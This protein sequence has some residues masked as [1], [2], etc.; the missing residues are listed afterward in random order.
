MSADLTPEKT[1]QSSA[2]DNCLDSPDLRSQEDSKELISW[3]VTSEERQDWLQALRGVSRQETPF[4]PFPGSAEPGMLATDAPG[5]KGGR[6]DFSPGVSKDEL[7]GLRDALT[8]AGVLDKTAA[9]SDGNSGTDSASDKTNDSPEGKTPAEAS[10]LKI[11]YPGGKKSTTCKL[12]G[13][14]NLVE[15]TSKDQKGEKTFYKDE[16][17]NK[18]TSRDEDGIE[19]EVK[20]EFKLDGKDL[21]Y[22]KPGGYVR[23][24]KADGSVVNERMLDDQSRLA[25]DNSGKYATALVRP[26]GS[27]VEAT[28]ERG[29]ITRVVETSKDGAAVTW[30]RTQD[31]QFRSDGQPP[32]HRKEIKLGVQ[33]R[34]TYEDSKGFTHV[35]TGAGSERI[36]PRIT[37]NEDGTSTVEIQYPGGT[38]F[39]N[40]TMDGKGNLV[41]FSEQDEDGRRHYSKDQSGQWQMKAGIKNVPVP[42]DFQLSKN[43]DFIASDKDMYDVQKPDGTIVHE[44]VNQQNGTRLRLDDN[45]NI[46]RLTR[47]DGSSVDVTWKDGEKSKLVETDKGGKE[48]TWTKKGDGTWESDGKPPE[49]RKKFD[50][51][52]EGLVIGEDVHGRRHVTLGDGTK[53]TEGAGGSRF[54]FD[55]DGKITSITYP[56]GSEWSRAELKYNESGNV[57]QFDRYDKHGKLVETRTRNGDTDKWQVKDGNGK[58]GGVWTGDVAVSPQ[59]HLMQ[60]DVSDRKNNVWTHTTPDFKTYHERTTDSGTVRTFL[61]KTEIA[62]N[63]DGMISKYTNGKYSRSFEYENGELS[64]ITDTSPSGSKTVN[65][66]DYKNV[67]VD[68]KTGEYFY[69][70]EGKVHIAKAN[71]TSIELNSDGL[72]T[73]V[74][75]DTGATRSFIYK[76]GSSDLEAIVDKRKV[77]D[78]EREDK[79]DCP[80]NPDGTYRLSKTGSDGKAQIRE[81]VEIVR[82]GSYKYKT[83]DGK[84]IVSRI[85]RVGDGSVPASVEEA[86]ERFMD[87][88]R[89]HFDE[90]RMKRLEQMT[91]NFEGR[92]NDRTE[93]RKL[94]G[95]TAADKIEEWKE[96]SMAQ[97]YHHLTQMLASDKQG[98]FYDQKTRARLAENFMFHAMDPTTMDQGP[99]SAGDSNGHGTCWIQAGHIWGMTQ[100]PDKMARLISQVALE[101]KFTTLNNG[102]KDPAARTF[103]FSNK[104]LQFREGGQ[105]AK[106]TIENAYGQRSSD[107]RHWQATDGHR[108]PVGR[109]FDFTLPVLAGR[110]EGNVDG[111]L[112]E[113]TRSLGFGT[114]RIMHM[115]TGDVPCDVASGNHSSGH[116]INNN[117]RQTLL[118]KGSVLNY[119]P[120]H[121]L[122]IHLKKVDG[123]WHKIQDNQHGESSD[124]L[125]AKITDLGKWASGDRSA[126]QQA[127]G[128]VRRH[129]L[130]LDG[131]DDAVGPVT[132]SQKDTPSPSPHPSSVDPSPNP[133][134]DP[135]SRR[136]KWIAPRPRRIIGWRRR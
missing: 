54:T 90:G 33:G 79:W 27:R 71:G 21:L 40:L 76:Q 107:G 95:V 89:E 46:T 30:T 68:P 20:G 25:L 64:K 109:I 2:Q 111:G 134:P 80:K 86:R 8:R 105:E 48:T 133:C 43:G 62:F 44:K 97:T 16:K 66:K 70:H 91:R 24:E 96:Q 53:V 119:W 123:E 26:D 93:A 129:K 15:F 82:D 63:K 72:V 14:G 34:Y 100:H 65:A 88:M 84:E 17:T 132:P 31:G 1:M 85:E 13:N 81:G 92:M 102:E 124:H 136:D 60:R 135:D 9:K 117:L 11:D 74:T 127:R 120:G 77:G 116:L 29:E 75:T 28:R 98:A 122:S 52:K 131:K 67:G 47:K 112:Y 12:D 125:V 59:G 61:D 23:T 50:V 3:P 113:D 103:S 58:D 130:S 73:K 10:T 110:R 104:Y 22:I 36:E 126:E 49:Q 39:R 57:S 118:E 55:K 121:M 45:G 4:E 99:A 106:W 69:E 35:I 37:K 78:K 42:G 101:G 5:L 94:A 19:S 41:K 56:Q 115:V 128:Q 87:T 108:S 83:A 18:W 114:R 7:I 32:E 38:Q 6:L 51:T